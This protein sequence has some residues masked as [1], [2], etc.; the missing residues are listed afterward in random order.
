MDINKNWRLVYDDTNVTLQFH[1]ER[2]RAKT[3]GTTEQY[4]FLDPHYFP[5]VKSALQ[6]FLK[7][8]LKYAIDVPDLINRIEQSEADIKKLCKNI[9]F[10]PPTV[11]DKKLEAFAEKYLTPEEPEN[12]VKKTRKKKADAE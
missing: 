9:K 2:T 11:L 6:G 10:T 8:N 4:E 3:D 7:R 5:D 1:E 12:P